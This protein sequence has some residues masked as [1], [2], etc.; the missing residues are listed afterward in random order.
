MCA[1]FVAA[2]NSLGTLLSSSQRIR[3]GNESRA[4][5]FRIMF[6]RAGFPT[7]CSV[8]RIYQYMIG[9]H[10]LGLTGTAMRHKPDNPN[11]R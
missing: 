3:G 10:A 9:E 1:Q 8:T 7:Q 5:A 2:P 4:A 11:C 6:C